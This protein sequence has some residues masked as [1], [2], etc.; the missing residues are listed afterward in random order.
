MDAFHTEKQPARLEPLH[1]P[2]ENCSASEKKTAR[3]E[4]VTF[5]HRELFIFSFKWHPDNIQLQAE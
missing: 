1:L 4:P 3:L 5:T 2:T